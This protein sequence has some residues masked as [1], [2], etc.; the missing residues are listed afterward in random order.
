MSGDDLRTLFTD[1]ADEVSTKD[2]AT[3]AAVEATRV[4]R[5]RRAIVA[6]ALALA[7]VTAGATLGLTYWQAVNSPTAPAGSAAATPTRNTAN[8]GALDYL[9][10]TL[11]T[12]PQAVPYWPATLRPAVNAPI[13]RADTVA[14]AVLLFTPYT[15]GDGPPPIYAYA[16]NSINGG[17]GDGTFGWYRVPVTLTDTRDAGGNRAQPLDPGSLA[18]DGARAAFAQLDEVIVVDLRTAKVDRIP[19]PGLNEDVVWLTDSDHLLVSSATKTSLVSTRAHTT[20]PVPV[21]GWQVAALVGGGGGLTTLSVGDS[22][23]QSPLVRWYDDGGL[24]QTEQ[25]FI[26]SPATIST[27][28][29]RGWRYGDLIAQ[30]GSGHIDGG[31]VDFVVVADAKQGIVARILDLGPGRNKGCCATLGWRN[32]S[33]VLVYTEQ[34]GLLTWDV[35]NGKIL[36][37]VPPAPGALSIATMGCDWTVTIEGR[38]AS[39]V[40]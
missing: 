30:A 16:A 18:P 32:P 7:V 21:S 6:S 33:S 5:R 3:V 36:R 19:L 22:G 14:H 8:Q 13:L 31:P 38:T 35:S 12:D 11:D 40:T 34:E 23:R 2:L 17:S 39:C 26:A 25:R 20:A 29:P 28:S 24:A 1:L 9:P 10:S 4:R 37:L 27:L 15:G